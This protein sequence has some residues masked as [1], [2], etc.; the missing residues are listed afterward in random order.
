MQ[1]TIA[2][3]R[4]NVISVRLSDVTLQSIDLLVNAGLFQSRS[5]AAAQLIKAGIQASADLLRQAQ[6][7]AENVQRVK[8]EFIEAVKRRDVEHV[9][10]LLEQDGR[11]INQQVEYGDTPLLMAVYYGAEEVKDLLLAKGVRLNVFEA[12]AVGDTGALSRMLESAPE[13]VNEYSHDGWTP[14]HLA[15][16]FGRVDAVRL[17]LGKGAQVRVLSRNQMGNTPLH[18][19]LAGRHEEIGSLLI[20]HGADVYATDSAGWTPLHHAAANGLFEVAKLLIE[21]GADVNS[22]NQQG[23]TPLMLAQQKERKDVA[24]LLKQSGANE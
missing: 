2:Q 13:L 8:Q 4:S 15:G 21:R 16:F 19:A 11:L 5:E 1:K 9:S 20:E 18:A 22:R 3:P 14:L 7:I 12:A 10:R 24:E 17:L 6:E 23:L